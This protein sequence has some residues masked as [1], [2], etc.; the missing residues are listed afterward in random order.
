MVVDGWPLTDDARPL[1]S[2]IFKALNL[3]F[4][5]WHL[6]LA[7]SIGNGARDNQ[8]KQQDEAR[9]DSDACHSPP[10]LSFRHDWK[11][12]APFEPEVDG[13]S[14]YHLILYLS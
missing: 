5:I 11:I 12:C 6:A 1:N 10:L 3:A 14:C 7:F 4:S 2:F 8:L 13:A 9:S